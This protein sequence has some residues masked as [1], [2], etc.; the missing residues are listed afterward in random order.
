M[1]DLR[2]WSTVRHASVSTQ[3]WCLTFSYLLRSNRLF[4][5]VAAVRGSISRV[6]RGASRVVQ[7]ILIICKST[8]DY[9]LCAT[10][11]S[12]AS[13][14]PFVSDQDHAIMLEHARTRYV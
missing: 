13:S 8:P 12:P 3:S 14:S 6:Q 1:R 9:G 5:H 10:I 4:H 11:N 7:I 2:V